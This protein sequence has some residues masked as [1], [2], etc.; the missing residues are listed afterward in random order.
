MLSDQILISIIIPT[1]KGESTLEKL[2]RELI[3]VFEKYKIEIIIVNDCSPDNTHEICKKLINEFPKSITYIQLSKNFG[4]HNAV[5]AGLRNC[6][7]DIALIMDDDYQNLP[8]ESLKLAEHTINNNYDVVFTSYK[9]KE[10]SF[11]RNLMSKIANYCAVSL[12]NKP[13]NLYLS[14]FKSIKRNLINEVVKYT[15]PFPYIDGLLLS[16][17]NNIG[18]CEVQHAARKNSKSSYNLFKLGK[19]FSNLII[20]F[21]TKPIHLFSSLGIII[22]IIS[23]ILLIITVIEK[24]IN[25]DLPQGYSYLISLIIFFSGVQILFLGLLGEYVG[26]I[27]K[28]INKEDQYFI[29]LIKK[30]DK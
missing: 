29:S 7:G 23:I 18:S 24:M 26:K 14:S 20:N 12:I 10:D 11:I 1:Y 30:R 28:N 6:D 2:T 22:L 17:T 9:I 13:K 8:S 15:G 5:M 21:S 25:P 16:K 3:K 27:L 4:E 19:H